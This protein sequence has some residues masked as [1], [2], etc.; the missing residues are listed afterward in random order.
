MGREMKWMVS[1]YAE[2]GREIGALRSSG[3]GDADFPTNS[4]GLNVAH[5]TFRNTELD[6]A[7]DPLPEKEPHV[8]RVD[9][10]F[11]ATTPAGANR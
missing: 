10:A 8:L 6:R 7:A 11:A 3:G 5:L 4:P 2:K 9:E 1:L